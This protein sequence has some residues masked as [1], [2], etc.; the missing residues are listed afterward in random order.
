LSGNPLSHNFVK[1]EGR[2]ICASGSGGV[3]AAVRPEARLALPRDDGFAVVVQRRDAAAPD[4][5]AAS[6]ETL[7]L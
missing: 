7:K 5:T 1:R 3:L 6:L 2:G 4:A